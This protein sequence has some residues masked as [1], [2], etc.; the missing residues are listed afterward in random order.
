MSYADKLGIP[1]VIFM[2]EDEIARDVVSCKDMSSGEQTALPFSQ[3]LERIRAGLAQRSSG[4][5][6]REKITTICNVSF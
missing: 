5:I 6:I 4:S 1:Y 2:G 3:T